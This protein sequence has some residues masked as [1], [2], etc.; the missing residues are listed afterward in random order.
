M[1]RYLNYDFL[2]NHNNMQNFDNWV[3]TFGTQK[4]EY[5]LA[6]AGNKFK[7]RTRIAE[8][9][10]LPELMSM[11]KMIADVRTADTLI[12]KSLTAN[13]ILLMLSRQNY[14]RNLLKNYQTEL[15]GSTTAP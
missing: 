2:V 15:M 7:E 12:L 9:A 1:M 4:K 5:E 3:S 14:K 8:Y 11:F 10:N 6:P 13:C